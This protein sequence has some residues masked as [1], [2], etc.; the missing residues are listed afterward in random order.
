MNFLD[1]VSSGFNTFIDQKGMSTRRRHITPSQELTGDVGIDVH[2]GHLPNR[3]FWMRGLEYVSDKAQHAWDEVAEIENV[4]EYSI[5]I[6]S[7]AIFTILMLIYSCIKAIKMFYHLASSWDDY[8]KL[9]E[10]FQT[11]LLST[12]QTLLEMNDN[13][14]ALSGNMTIEEASIKTIVDAANPDIIAVQTVLG[15]IQNVTGSAYDIAGLLL[16]FGILTTTNLTD[17]TQLDQNPIVS[18]FFYANSIVPILKYTCIIGYFAGVLIGLYS[19]YCVLVQHKR[20]SLALEHALGTRTHVIFGKENLDEEDAKVTLLGIDKKYKIG[21]SVYFFGILMSTAVV[22]MHIFGLSI[23]CALAIIIDLKNFHIL[24]NIGGYIIFVYVAVILTNVGLTKIVGN[25]LIEDGYHVNRPWLFFIYLFVFSTIH[26]V[27]GLFY[28]LWRVLLL[29][30]TT[31]WV[32]NR[33]DVSF[34]LTGKGFD[35]GHYSFMSMLLL[36]RVIRLTNIA[37]GFIV[38]PTIQGR[39]QTSESEG[40]RLLFSQ[41]EN[42]ISRQTSSVHSLTPPASE[43]S[44]QN[45]LFSPRNV[46]SLQIPDNSEQRSILSGGRHSLARYSSADF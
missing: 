12:H 31:F 44:I 7:A 19:L 24:L 42:G 33:L 3:P 28:A 26:V 40:S 43:A 14:A 6:K 37:Q 15:S 2:L 18:A 39:M 10:A 23:T 45:G 1:R 13:L 34:M 25:R 35:N 30:A 11:T 8:Y 16:S 20:M 36:T 4:F 17:M 41:Y 32:L 27:L 22:Q 5:W 9:T 21:G 38:A 29:L 46:P